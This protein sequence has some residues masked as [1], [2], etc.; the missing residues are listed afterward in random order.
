MSGDSISTP[1]FGKNHFPLSTMPIT[2]SPLLAITMQLNCCQTKCDMED[3]V[4]TCLT[5]LFAVGKE[6][7][8][9]KW[10]HSV[11]R[12]KQMVT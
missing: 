5:K 10:Y 6:M 8:F 7:L 1:A 4:L 3:S 2:P 12:R 11:L 9:L